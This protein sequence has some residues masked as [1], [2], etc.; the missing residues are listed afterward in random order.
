MFSI[1]NLLYDDECHIKQMGAIGTLKYSALGFFAGWTGDE[2]RACMRA[3]LLDLGRENGSGPTQV[4]RILL[5][6]PTVAGIF[7]STGH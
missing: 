6:Y 4:Q 2:S 3:G 1:L 5:P 7:A